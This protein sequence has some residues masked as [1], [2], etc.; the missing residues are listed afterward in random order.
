MCEFC[1]EHGEGKK[2]Y[3]QMK[4]YAKE[5]L[6]EEL[7]STG[8][9]KTKATTRLEWNLRFWETFVMPA[10]TGVSGE[11]SGTS[12]T[13][14]PEAQPSEDEILERRK[15][16]HFGQVL[17]IED[18]EEVVVK[19]LESVPKNATHW[20][21]RSMAKHTGMSH[22]TISRI[23]RAFGLQ[24]HRLETFKISN[25]PYL[26][27]KVRDVVGL[28]LN[29]PERAL[30]FCVDEKS[31]IQALDR[32][33]PLLPIRPG[34]VE[35]QTHD[36]IRHGTSSLFAAF[37]ITSGEVIG[38]CYRKHRSIEFRK[39]LDIIDQNVPDDLDV[40]LI[41]DNYSTHKTAMIHNWLLKRTRFTLHFTPTSSSWI[42]LVERWF[43]EITRQRIRRGTFTSIRKLEKA[44]EDWIAVYKE[45]PK[46]FMW[47]KTA[48]E[49]LKSIKRFCE[50]NYVT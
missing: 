46:P 2:W 11:K 41:L 42:N 3:L 20:S 21:T 31:Q 16:V 29:P 35:K 6:H 40:H 7:S 50:V 43:G 44:I 36:Y 22:Q 28:Y 45:D 24:P 39:F 27:E 9:E 4:N 25:D 17:P 48:D 10:I 38:K 32:T 30:V 26:I 8:R 1:A 23:W 18:V 12:S 34:V 13:G 37:N 19:T 47:T 5:L 49:I 33:Q 14:A 15:V